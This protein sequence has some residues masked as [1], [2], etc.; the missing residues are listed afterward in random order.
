[1]PSEPKAAEAEAAGEAQT[2]CPRCHEPFDIGSWPWCPHG[3]PH[4]HVHSGRLIWTDQQAYGLK[5]TRSDEYRADL[6]A[7]M[8]SEVES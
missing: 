7:D 2:K 3:R 6:H 8:L 1:M 4:F 5:K